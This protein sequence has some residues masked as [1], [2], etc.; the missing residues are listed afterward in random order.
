M[1]KKLHP[2]VL[3]G[4]AILGGQV[5]NAETVKAYIERSHVPL[6]YQRDRHFTPAQVAEMVALDRASGH[7]L[8]PADVIAAAKSANAKVFVWAEEPD[9]THVV[10]K[11]KN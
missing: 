3:G 7:P 10:L 4:Y 5:I 2:R 11:K 8:P 6:D 9:A 1:S